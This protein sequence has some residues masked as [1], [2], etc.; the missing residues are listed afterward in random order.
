MHMMAGL[1]GLVRS[2]QTLWLTPEQ[3]KRLAHETGLPLD[4]GDNDCPAIDPKHCESLDCGT[5]EEVVGSPAVCLMHGCPLPNT[6]K[7]L[8]C[9]SSDPLHTISLTW[10]YP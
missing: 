8:F 2:R 5:W 3:A 4:H 7:V 10:H 9:P 6:Q 1:A